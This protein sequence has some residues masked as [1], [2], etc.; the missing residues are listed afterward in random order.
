MLADERRTFLDT[1]GGTACYTAD[2]KADSYVPVQGIVGFA[3]VDRRAL[4]L[5]AQ[6]GISENAAEYR[7]VHNSCPGG[8]R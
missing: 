2:Q 7:A 6:K 4:H 8:R 3:A 1:A 5:M